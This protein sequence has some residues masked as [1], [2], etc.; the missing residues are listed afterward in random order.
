LLAHGRRARALSSP[1]RYLVDN[2]W[3]I[4]V[5]IG[6]IP[7]AREAIERLSDQGLA[8]S[9]IT[10]GELY[11]GAYG[12]PDP[13]RHLASFRAFL[14]PL[15]IVGLTDAIMELF[16]RERSRLRRAGNLIPDF[17]LLIV[18]TSLHYDLTLL[19]RNLRHFSPERL[20]TLRL[21]QPA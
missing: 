6:R 17:D 11:D 3:I 2:D 9:I 20:P 21:Y 18:A 12:Y 10:V 16:A 1:P 8:V 19:T 7:A 13:E 14:A 4:D 15:P 5:L